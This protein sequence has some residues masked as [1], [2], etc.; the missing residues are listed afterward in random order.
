MVFNAG[1]LTQGAYINPN[2]LKLKKMKKQL[3]AFL[4]MAIMGMFFSCRKEQST[5]VTAD[6]NFTVEN[7]RYTIP[8]KIALTNTSSG[9]QF[10]R[11]TFDGATTTGYDKREP[12]TI[13]FTRPSPSGSKP[14][15]QR[16]EKKKPLPCSLTAW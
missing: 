1:R 15:T 16:S 14:G 4:I 2:H 12:G 9:A 6:F 13:V 3:Q 10:Y 11:W 7:N 5:P 8:V